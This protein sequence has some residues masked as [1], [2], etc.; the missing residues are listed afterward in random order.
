MIKGYFDGSPLHEFF[1][2]L[3]Y[4]FAYDV[5]AG[6]QDDPKNDNRHMNNIK[7]WLDDMKQPGPTWYW[8]DGVDAK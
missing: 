3:L 6:I 5:L 8:R 7:C 2:V 1:A 4:Y